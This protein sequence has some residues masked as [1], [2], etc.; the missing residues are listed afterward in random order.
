[1]LPCIATFVVHAE[2]TKDLQNS[3]MTKLIEMLDIW[4]GSHACMSVLDQSCFLFAGWFNLLGQAAVT[5]GIDFTLA[6]HLA[7][8]WLLADG[9]VFTQNELLATYASEFAIFLRGLKPCRM[10]F[11]N[12]RINCHS[13]TAMFHDPEVP[14]LSNPRESCIV[15]IGFLSHMQEVHGKGGGTAQ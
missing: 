3:E 4:P 1:M 2:L 7:A 10:V 6:N 14:W 12:H 9:H 13:Y 15:L 8:M 11:S 5:A